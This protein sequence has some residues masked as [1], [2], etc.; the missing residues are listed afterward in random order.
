[1]EAGSGAFPGCRTALP[2]RHKL[3]ENIWGGKKFAWSRS[4][5]ALIQSSGP[6]HWHKILW[7]PSHWGAISWSRIMRLLKHPLAE[8]NCYSKLANVP[9]GKIHAIETWYL[10]VQSADDCTLVNGGAKSRNLLYNCLTFCIARM[11]SET[12][13]RLHLHIHATHDL[14]NH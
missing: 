14:K 5:S 7:L 4:F 8:I 12:R 6:T 3:D 1:M 11:Q 9:E 10:E 13:H 2:S